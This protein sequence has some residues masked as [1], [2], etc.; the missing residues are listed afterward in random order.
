MEAKVHFDIF[1]L[2]EMIGA[3]YSDG[4]MIQLADPNGESKTEDI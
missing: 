2:R 4:A 1:N 3:E